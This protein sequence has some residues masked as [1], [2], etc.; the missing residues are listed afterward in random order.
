MDSKP[1]LPRKQKSMCYCFIGGGVGGYIQGRNE[2]KEEGGPGEKTWHWVSDPL[3]SCAVEDLVSED[4]S[5]R[6]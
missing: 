2:R 1:E 4:S 6:R 3:A 5:E